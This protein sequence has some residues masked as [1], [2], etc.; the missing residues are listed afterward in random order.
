MSSF[1][2]FFILLLALLFLSVPIGFALGISA[3]SFL[4]FAQNI[5][6]ELVVQRM[7]AAADSFPLMALPFFILSGNIMQ[8]GGISRRLINFV[9]SFV[10]WISGGLSIVTILSSMFFGAISG[11]ATATTAAIGSIMIPGMTKKGYDIEYSSAVTASSGLLGAVIPPSL[12]MVTYGTLTGVSVSALF[13]GGLIPGVIMGGSLMI[14]S[15]AI[16]KKAGYSSGETFAISEV[17]ST[18]KEAFFALMMPII[19]LGGIYGGIFTPTEAAVVSVVYTILVA[20]FVY[21]EI[22]LKDLPEIFIDSAK[23]SGAIM[24]L[25]STASFFG[26]II[27]RERIPQLIAEGFLSLSNNPI[28]VLLLINILLLLVGCFLESIAAQVILT[29]ILFPLIVQLGVD[30][31]HFGIIVC[32]NICIG[33][34]TPPFGVCL[35]VTSGITGVPLERI[36]KKSLPFLFILIIDL[37]LLTYLPQLTLFLPNLL[38]G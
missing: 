10:G 19:V 7:V 22:T 37:L 33:T 30:P 36:A 2:V 18:F 27:T 29:P 17:F 14:L 16:A 24:F 12:M 35:F 25:V 4:V 26:W 32:I 31:L 34:L 9:N 6:Y 21:R 8:S 5:P 15:Y 3:F 11:S 20:M 28:V 1:I 38:A 23:V 13:V